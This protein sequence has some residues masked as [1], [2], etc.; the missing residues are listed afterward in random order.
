MFVGLALLQLRKKHPV[1]LDTPMTEIVEFTPYENRWEDKYPLSLAHLMEHT[2]GITDM[3]RKEF[4]Y[5]ESLSLLD[6]F[7]VDPESRRQ[8][9]QPG[10]HHSYSNSGSGIA[11]Y[12]IEQISGLQFEDFVETEVFE[13][14]GLDSATYHPPSES[15]LNLT[16]GYDKDG[17]T[18]IPYWHTLYRAF[19][20]I[21]IK[22]IEMAILIRMYLNNGRINTKQVFSAGEIRRMETPETTLAAKSGLTHGYGLGLYHFIHDGFQFIGHGG[23]ADGY[24]SYLAYSRELNLGYFVSF[25]AFNNSAMR[26]IRNTIQDRLIEDKTKPERP[27]NYSLSSSRQ[28]QIQGNYSA[29]TFRFG[30]QP[31]DHQL[32]IIIR[33]KKLFTRYRNRDRELIPVTSSHFRRRNEP[34]AT[35]AI[36]EKDDTVYFQGDLGNFRKNG[37]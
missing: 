9:W 32:Q 16:A 26:Q 13:P 37:S 34:V 17:I 28:K 33:D 2:A 22:P 31:A 4:S 30:K 21:N 5:E 3:S 23:D 14:I 29:V 12:A 25:N 8:K 6:A 36:V 27:K 11:A 10:F 35:I 18:P 7:Q 20:G 24:L 19:G 15:S 1:T